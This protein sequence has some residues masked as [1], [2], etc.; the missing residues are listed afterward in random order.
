MHTSSCAT[1]SNKKER[2]VVISTFYLFDTFFKSGFH[3]LVALFDFTLL[4]K[5]HI[6]NPCR[7]SRFCQTFAQDILRPRR[8]IGHI[9]AGRRIKRSERINTI[10]HGCFTSGKSHQAYHGAKW[11]K[12][13]VF[14]IKLKISVNY[15][16]Q[17]YCFF[18]KYTNIF[19]QKITPTFG[20]TAPNLHSI[21]KNCIYI[22]G[23]LRNMMS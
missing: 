7:C 12:K 11:R 22:V 23:G 6:A 18:L 13:N 10:G 1:K 21:F 15:Q 19:F 4:N 5:R 8:I 2:I 20:I 3:C 9:R 17:R 16:Q 14:F